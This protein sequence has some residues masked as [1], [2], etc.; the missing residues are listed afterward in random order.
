[1]N[2]PEGASGRPGRR[3]ALIAGGV[4]AVA[5]VAVLGYLAL[6]GQGGPRTPGAG[7]T[8]SPA[9]SPTSTAASPAV[10]APPATTTVPSPAGTGAGAPPAPVTPF[11][12][13]EMA[14][15][16]LDAASERQSG[17]VVR[18]DRIEPVSGEAKL[19]GEVSGPALRFSISIHNG[20]STPID[21]GAVVVNAYAGADETPLEF[22]TTPG[23]EP[24]S[25]QVQPGDTGRGVY[26][27]SVRGI[28]QAEVT[29]TVDPKAGEPA[30]VFRGVAPR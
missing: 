3:Q 2:P 19:P 15:V 5:V 26:L 10:T 23:G 25:G 27:F 22:M 8:S 24:F 6:S 28:D 11:A 7:P 14:P 21:L 16:P 9:S 30:S 29:L 12:P 20:G 1:M 17:V 18:L 13:P 4:V